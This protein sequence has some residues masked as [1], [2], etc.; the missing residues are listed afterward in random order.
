MIGTASEWE[1]PSLDFHRRATDLV[2]PVLKWGRRRRDTPAGTVHFYTDDYKFSRLWLDPTSLFATGCRVAIEVNF[3]THAGMSRAEALWGIYRKRT[4]SRAWQAAGID[5]V[6]DLNVDPKFRD[7]TLLGVPPG[8]DA[9]ATRIHR[10]VP[11]GQVEADHAMAAAHAGRP[12]PSFVVFGGGQQVQRACAA[13]DWPWIP[14]HWQLAERTR[15]DDGRW[16]ERRHPRPD[17]QGAGPEGG[18]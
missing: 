4:L 3:S 6:V 15:P 17:R 10:S 12:D 7:L 11:F 14:E 18:K 2:D 8:W 16:S 9:Y 1:I 13:R 5:I